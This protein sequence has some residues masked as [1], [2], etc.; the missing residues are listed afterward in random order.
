MNN[1]SIREAT[2]DDKEILWR[3]LAIAAYE[4]SAEA[5]KRVPV[6][7]AHLAGWKRP[8]DFGVIAETN[9]ATIGAA[10]ARQYRPSEQPVFF[11]GSRIPEVSI[12]VLP[13]AR[14]QGVGL[15]LLRQLEHRGRERNCDGLC[16]NVRDSNPAV[17]LYARAGYQ[18]VPGSEVLNRVGGLS[19]G[20][21]LRF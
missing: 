4:L 21:L 18:L 1:F 13:A 3:F 14:N 5:A 12:G 8:G 17:R 10:W 20:M 7:A 16:L 6:V 2:D 19:L 11:P 15:A 9:L